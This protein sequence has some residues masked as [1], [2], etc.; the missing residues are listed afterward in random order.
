MKVEFRFAVDKFTD[1]KFPQ[2]I[3]RQILQTS[4]TV[5]RVTGHGDR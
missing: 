5:Q 1:S 4:D 2:N 3:L